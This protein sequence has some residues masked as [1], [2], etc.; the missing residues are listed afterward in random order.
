MPYASKLKDE[1]SIVIVEL[2]QGSQWASF[3][4]QQAGVTWLVNHIRRF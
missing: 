2:T 4:A 1:D 3:S